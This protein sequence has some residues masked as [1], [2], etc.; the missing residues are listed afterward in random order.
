MSELVQRTRRAL[1][2]VLSVLALAAAARFGWAAH[3]QWDAARV[4]EPAPAPGPAPI[5]PP[6]A[7]VAKPTEPATPLGELVHVVLSVSH[8]NRRSEVLY[9]GMSVGQTTYAGDQSCHLGSNVTIR[10]IPKHGE[11]IERVRRCDG[12]MIVVREP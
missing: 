8:G 10:I 7:P 12:D 2:I 11:P 5:E 4:R 9:E 1:Q 6:E 3:A